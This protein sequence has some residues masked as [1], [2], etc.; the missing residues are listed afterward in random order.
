MGLL[1]RA[2]MASTLMKW[3]S[4]QASLMEETGIVEWMAGDKSALE[5]R[6]EDAQIEFG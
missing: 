3:D 1:K 2:K 5:P 6:Q 4:K